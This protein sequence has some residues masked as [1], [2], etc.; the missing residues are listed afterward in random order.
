MCLLAV[1]FGAMKTDNLFRRGYSCVRD[2][3]TNASTL[4]L[5][6]LVNE[7]SLVICEVN[8]SFPAE[9]RLTSATGCRGVS[10]GTGL[11]SVHGR[12]VNLTTRT[13]HA[14]RCMH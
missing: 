7:F 9:T 5:G 1:C 6:G 4:E 2:K 10:F 3:A 13:P 8:E 14:G 11:L 12:V